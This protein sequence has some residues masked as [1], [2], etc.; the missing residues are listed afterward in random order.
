MYSFSARKIPLGSLLEYV[1]NP[2]LT[3]RVATDN[4]IEYKGKLMSLSGA[5]LNILESEGVKKSSI[6]G[7]K[8][9]KYNGTTL[10]KLG[11]AE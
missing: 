7:P 6:Q 10:T 5:A 4:K 9:W 2:N 3:A 8:M 11:I 1:N